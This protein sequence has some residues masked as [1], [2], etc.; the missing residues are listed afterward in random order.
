MLTPKYQAAIFKAEFY[1]PGHCPQ[2]AAPA[3]R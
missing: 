1:E 2:L 3:A